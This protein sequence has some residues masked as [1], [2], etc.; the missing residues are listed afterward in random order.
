MLNPPSPQVADERIKLAGGGGEV[1][2]SSVMRHA[3]LRL[4]VHVTAAVLDERDD[5]MKSA[6]HFPPIALACAI[7]C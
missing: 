1:A 3:V 5:G 6:H 2:P 4:V 7:G